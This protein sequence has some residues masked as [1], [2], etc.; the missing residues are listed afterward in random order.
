[1]LVA[2]EELVRRHGYSQLAFNVGGD[3][4]AARA[5]YRRAEYSVTS[6]FLSKN[7]TTE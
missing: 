6:E 7:V 4:H 5:L 3:N 1:M 2:A